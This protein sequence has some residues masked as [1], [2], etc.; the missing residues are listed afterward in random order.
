M[1]RYQFEIDLR[2]LEQIIPLLV[3]GNP[4]AL[5]YWRRRIS[6][7]LT[8]QGLP[9]DANRRVTRLLGVFDEVERALIS[10]KA[11]ARRSPG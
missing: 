3:R 5:S 4:L 11:A 8:Q 6:S 10:G 1:S 7:L 2:H 9:P